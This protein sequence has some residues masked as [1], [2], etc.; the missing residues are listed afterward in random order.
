M[1]KVLVANYVHPA[2]LEGL[3]SLGFEVVYEPNFNPDDL[4]H[5]LPSLS[6]VVIN[7]KIKMTQTRI[8]MATQ[9]EFIARLGSGLDIMTYLPRKRKVLLYLVRRK[10]IV[11]QWQNMHWV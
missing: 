4:E 6:G 8:N 9:L 11:M 5:L 10:E 2:L 7:T 3:Q 1:K